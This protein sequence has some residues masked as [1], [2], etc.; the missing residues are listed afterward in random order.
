MAKFVGISQSF[1]SCF[2]FEA[3]LDPDKYLRHPDYKIMHIVCQE[4]SSPSV[5]RHKKIGMILPSNKL[6]QTRE[7]IQHSPN[8]QVGPVAAVE[9]SWAVRAH[10]GE[11]LLLL[12]KLGLGV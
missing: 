5:T 1:S 3:L 2:T 12:W 4:M 8:A 6:K 10:P 11:V 9:G 7:A